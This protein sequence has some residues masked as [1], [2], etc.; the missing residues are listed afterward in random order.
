MVSNKKIADILCI[1][2]ILYS[3]FIILYSR[4][5]LRPFADKASGEVVE[6]V[7]KDGKHALCAT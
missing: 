6:R 7:Y 2:C 1:T 5:W 4:G 3:L